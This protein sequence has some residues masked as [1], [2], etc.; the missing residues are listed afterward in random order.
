VV[1]PVGVPR[2]GEEGRIRAARGFQHVLL[3]ERVDAARWRDTYYLAHAP[4]GTPLADLVAVLRSG[5]GLDASLA[6]ARD[7]AGTDQYE[8]RTWKAWYRH[9]TLAMLAAAP[10]Q[11]AWR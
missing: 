11:V 4:V 1:F 3:V 5:R 9:V 6:D 7:R 2:S 8:V 10:G